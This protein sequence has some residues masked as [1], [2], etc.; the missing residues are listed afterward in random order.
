MKVQ[1]LLL[2]HA[3]VAVLVTVVFPA[4]KEDPLAG[5]L[6]TLTAEQVP[7]AVTRN[8]TLLLHVP[9]AA[10]TVM[11]AGQMI[12]G[13]VVS[14]KMIRWLTLVALPHASVAVHVAVFVCRQLVPLA[15]KFDTTP[16]ALQSANTGA[17]NTS[18]VPH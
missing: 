15:A 18:V 11:S 4:G 14:I 8:V 1:V 3:S 16:N 7:V 10:F 12:T 6:V 9:G 17:V 2:P 13:A 5:T